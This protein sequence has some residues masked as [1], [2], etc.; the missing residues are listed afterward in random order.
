MHT[1]RAKIH[2]LTNQMQTILGYLEL[3]EYTK[4]LKATKDA[5]RELRSI[6]T[7][8]SGHLI[9]VRSEAVIV[10]DGTEVHEASEVKKPAPQ[11]NA[12]VVLPKKDINLK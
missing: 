10:P 5:I 8:L 12:V 4:A 3:E 2:I 9:S 11:K 1:L 6:A 7:V